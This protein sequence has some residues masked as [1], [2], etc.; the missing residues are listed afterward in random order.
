MT[1]KFL[2]VFGLQKLNRIE[3]NLK[4]IKNVTIEV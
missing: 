2:I 4:I 1:G 3:E